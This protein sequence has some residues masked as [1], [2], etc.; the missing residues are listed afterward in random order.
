ML[1]N[2]PKAIQT[3]REKIGIPV[4]P[5]VYKSWVELKQ[6]E[7]F[8]F[9]DFQSM[10]LTRCNEAFHREVPWPIELWVLAMCGEAGEA[11]N[12]VKKVIRSGQ[13]MTERQ[14]LAIIEEI[15]DVMC[16]ADLA[17]TSLGGRTQ[18]AVLK[19]FLKVNR[20]TGWPKPLPKRKPFQKKEAA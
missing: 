14:R 11:A 7:G 10:N 9:D 3:L 17:I 2:G 18:D 12:K 8:K 20:K 6:A 13:P 5:E 15:A 1:G 16:Y 4:S 19:K